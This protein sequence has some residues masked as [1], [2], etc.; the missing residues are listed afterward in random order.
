[1]EGAGHFCALL[2]KNGV[3]AGVA[4][5]SREISCL[6][7]KRKVGSLEKDRKGGCG[8]QAAELSFRKSRTVCTACAHM[9]N[10]TT[11]SQKTPLGEGLTSL[12]QSQCFS[13]PDRELLGCEEMA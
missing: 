11:S 5:G 10:T 7:C 9:P 3:W 12:E 13:S 8:S 6:F 2:Y 1:M 4:S